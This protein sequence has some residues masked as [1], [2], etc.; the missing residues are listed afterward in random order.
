MSRLRAAIVLFAVVAAGLVAP[1]EARAAAVG[2]L[3][4]DVLALDSSKTSYSRTSGPE[5]VVSATVSA[6]NQ[7][8]LSTSS[9]TAPI[10]TLTLGDGTRPQSGGYYLLGN[11]TNNRI[12][13]ICGGQSSGHLAVDHVVYSGD[14]VTE[15]YAR[16]GTG[17]SALGW[18]SGLIRVGVTTPYA[19]ARTAPVSMGQVPASGHSVPVRFVNTGTGSTGTLEAATVGTN[20]VGQTDFFVV[21]DGCAGRTLAPG[22]DCT[23]DIGFKRDTAGTSY[24]LVKVPDVSYPGRL[25]VTG[26][27]ATGVPLPQGPTATHPFAVRGGQGV[28]WWGTSGQVDHYRVQ[29]EEAGGWTDVSGPLAP[30]TQTWVDTSLAPG[31]SRTYRVIASNLAGDGPA[32]P[33]AVA[34]RPAQDA[35]LGTVGAVSVDA[36]PVENPVPAQV[37][38]DMR[39]AVDFPDLWTTV[40]TTDLHVG[41][42][43]LLPGPG[44]YRL[45]DYPTSDSWTS[46]WWRGCND[47]STAT[48]DVASVSYTAAGKLENLT[49]AL[50]DTCGGRAS[51]TEVRFNSTTEV[52]SLKVSPALATVPETR[53]GELS[54]TSHVDVENLGGM[55]VA[56]GARTLTGP[57]AGDWTIASDDCGQVLAAGARCAIDV[58]ATP[59]R[60][61]DRNVRLDIAD[62]TPIGT[63]SAVINLHAIA[64]PSAP[65]GVTAI[66]LPFGPVDLSWGMPTEDGGQ[67]ATQW[68]IRRQSGGATATFTA[69]LYR[70]LADLQAPLDASY[71]VSMEN[72]VGDGAASAPVT[73]T[74]ASDVLAIKDGST[75]SAP[76]PRL[77]GL[78]LP[79]GRQP[80]RWSAPGV[81]DEVVSGTGSPNGQVLATVR[82]GAGGGYEVWRQPIDNSS[83]AVRLW[84][85]DQRIVSLEWS[86]DGTRLAIWTTVPT[87][88]CPSAT[89]VV[90]VASGKVL[91]TIPNALGAVWLPDSRTLV[92]VDEAMW[93][94][95]RFDAASGARGAQ[96]LGAPRGTVPSL[97]PDGALI[98]YNDAVTGRLVV[99]PL[100][101]GAAREVADVVRSSKAVWAPDSRTL[102]AMAY[103][104]L[105]RIPV[106]TAGVPSQ[107]TPFDLGATR[108]QEPLAWMGRRVAIK[109]M[110]AL[111]GSVATVPIDAAGFPA[112]TSLTCAVDAGAFVPCTTTWKTPALPS[113]VHTLRA[114]TVEPGGRTTVTARTVVV[115]AAAPVARVTAL[116]VGL[117][118]PGTTLR[119][120][121]TD[122]GGSTVASYDVRYRAA[123]PA[124]SFTALSQPTAWQGLRSTSLA[125]TL[126]RGYTY[127]YSVR[128][129]DALGNVGTWTAETCTSTA[130]D[131]RSL[132]ATGWT[133]AAS[134]SYYLGTYTT[135]ATSGR[136][137]SVR[138]SARQVG[139]VV[140]TCST[141]GTLDVR[142]GGAYLGRKSLVSS[143]ARAKQVVW[144]PLGTLRTGTLT[145]TTVGAKRVYVDGVV[146]RH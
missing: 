139:L 32:S 121:A 22:E 79:G 145:L 117:V 120:S 49:A 105:V 2:L 140:T 142:L 144:L 107:P 129:R 78:A 29:A 68:N 47:P 109:P 100:A 9:P 134:A 16:Y 34:S 40:S 104:G 106:S 25:L 41:L 136:V 130:L 65:T 17:C 132:T 80:L 146:L 87:N 5:D 42:P 28:A 7:I 126:G 115:D 114:R 112:G 64:L 122:S 67:G 138:A 66:R 19:V 8:V 75:S 90:D 1:T 15:L 12:S 3:D 141:C 103:G 63:H 43:P 10:V 95:V 93:N 26:I 72:T 135:A 62:S 116:P 91:S 101:G 77:S 137:L 81:P 55:P 51:V 86:P 70:V 56:L 45:A 74:V 83:P 33:A 92:A 76:T 111:V 21:A 133:R 6:T 23:V 69:T 94:L 89:Y 57:A 13:G 39:V 128:A 4:R 38:R 71:T 73:P 127:C 31:S 59:T 37:Q 82:W 20:I 113:G 97:S 50:R 14:T 30:T 125:V 119:F 44:T 52:T 143:T 61:G 84:A 36:E 123:S 27:T 110:P 124:G 99:A 53:A 35:E 88:C 60:S 98:S 108:G 96:L 48:L 24:S 11:T 46:T 118:A 58:A 85:T 131:D 18:S 54:P 102:V